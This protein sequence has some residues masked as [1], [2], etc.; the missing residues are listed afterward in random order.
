MTRD[1]TRDIT[2]DSTL[3]ITRE[4][5]GFAV[6]FWN[7]CVFSPQLY[8]FLKISLIS[9]PYRCLFTPKVHEGMGLEK[10]ELVFKPTVL[11][12]GRVSL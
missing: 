12:A 11:H 3:D 6:D 7:P 5:I 8:I 10:F 2:R 1:I 4:W 9:Y